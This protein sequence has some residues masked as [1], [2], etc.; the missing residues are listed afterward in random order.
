MDSQ[1]DDF[2]IT[3]GLIEFRGGFNPG[4]TRHGDIRHNDLRFEFADSVNE[5]LSITD[6]RDHFIKGSEEPRNLLQE[7]RI[8]FC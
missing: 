1:K 6:T 7:F 5:R 8:V 4:E 3:A 2:R